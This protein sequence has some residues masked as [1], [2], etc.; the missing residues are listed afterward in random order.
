M[1]YLSAIE[2]DRS[3]F[4]YVSKFGIAM[5]STK[6]LLACLLTPITF[7]GHIGCSQPSAPVAAVALPTSSPDVRHSPDDA[8]A[9][10]EIENTVNVKFMLR[11]YGYAG[12]KIKDDQ[13]LGG[14][15]TSDNL[16]K[17]IASDLAKSS[18]HCYLLAQPTV[19]TD[20]AGSKGMRL[21]LV[22]ATKD[23]VAFGASDSRLYIVQEAKS[24]SGKWKPI[25]YLPSSFCGNSYHR[26]LLGPSEY[27]IFPVPRY[28]GTFPTTL[29]FRLMLDRVKTPFVSNEFNGSIN[30]EQFSIKRPYN[31]NNPLAQRS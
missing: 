8:S 19:V 4:V 14:F 21:T 26:V 6:L 13:A 20:F 15:G 12:S 7:C 30:P 29:R 22:N 16:P 24:T 18:E 3:Q 28:D 9:T 27:W 2:P 5:F 11:G 23:V 31:Q 1:I 17:S 10:P 25:E